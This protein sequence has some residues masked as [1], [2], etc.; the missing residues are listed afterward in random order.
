MLLTLLMLFKY[1]TP[2]TGK[3]LTLDDAF[4]DDFILAMVFIIVFNAAML[5]MGWV[6]E[7]EYITPLYERNVLFAGFLPFAFVFGLCGLV[8]AYNYSLHG[9]VVYLCTL[10]IWAGY[11]INAAYNLDQP[12]QKASNYNLLDIISKNIFALVVAIEVLTTSRNCS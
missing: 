9:F 8:L 5:V 10:F 2:D 11:G 7:A 3:C 4:D 12:K 1:W 6:V